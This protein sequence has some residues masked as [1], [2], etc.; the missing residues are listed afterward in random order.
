[1]Q[2]S[3]CRHFEVCSGCRLDAN[4]PFPDVWSDVLIYFDGKCDFSIPF[5]DGP[6]TKWRN[7]AKLAVRGTSRNPL[8]GLFKERSH[9]VVPIPFCEIHYP[10]INSSVEMIHQFIQENH[11]APYDEKKR[12]GDLRYLQFVVERSSRKVQVVFVL[13]FKDLSSPQAKK[14]RALVESLG[15]LDGGKHWHSLWIN[16]NDRPLNT[17]FGEEWILCHGDELINE[18]FGDITVCHQPSSF[19]QAN[20][21]LFE[22]MLWRIKTLLEPKAKVAE[23]YAGGGVIGLFLTSKS[24]WVRCAE[25]N[26]HAE[27]CFTLSRALLPTS[28]AEKISFHTGTA[29]D[30]LLILAD[31]SVAVVDPPRKGLDPGLLG[32]FNT[33]STL[34]TLFYVS[35][36]WDSFKRDCDEL[37]SGGWKLTHGE[38]YLFFPGSDYIEILARFE[39]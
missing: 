22:K 29:D 37:L 27:S 34:H 20:L 21:D 13:N 12:S 30:L 17:I 8:I 19:A 4:T 18:R 38:G 9:E 14:W 26:P 16:L 31:A 5:Y 36:G 11:L 25:I 33:S 28:E 24:E 3:F 1:M 39:K 7:R 23:F 35:C 15:R 6:R 32:A 2:N 10:E